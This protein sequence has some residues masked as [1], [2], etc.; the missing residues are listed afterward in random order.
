MR[1]DSV[2]ATVII[3]ETCC[4]DG[5]EDIKD[6]GKC[7]EII[8]FHGLQKHMSN[9]GPRAQRCATYLNFECA[10]LVLHLGPRDVD[11]FLL[12]RGRS[13]PAFSSRF[14]PS[15]QSGAI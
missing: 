9:L 14:S 6:R 7:N 11:R 1:T 15:L 5:K 8:R 2:Q 12:M 4:D 13:F 3:V 10:D